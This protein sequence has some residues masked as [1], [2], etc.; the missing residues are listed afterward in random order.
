MNKSRA[1]SKLSVLDLNSEVY[2]IKG[3][4]VSEAMLLAASEKSFFVSH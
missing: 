3:I 4:N 2:K 1:P